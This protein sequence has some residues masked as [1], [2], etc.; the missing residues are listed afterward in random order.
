MDVEMGEQGLD[1]KNVS[2]DQVALLANALKTAQDQGFMDDPDLR[3]L[4]KLLAVLQ[5]E[6]WDDMTSGAFDFKRFTRQ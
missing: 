1:I 5:S 3:K 4:F 6:L 2:R